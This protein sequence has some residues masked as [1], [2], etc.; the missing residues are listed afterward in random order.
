[1]LDTRPLTFLLA[2]GLAVGLA[3]S[4]P[5]RAQDTC[6]GG[7]SAV[8]DNAVFTLDAGSIA[9]MDVSGDSISKA[10]NGRGRF[11]CPNRD[12]EHFNWA[13][14]DTNGLDFCTAGSEGVY[15]Q[16]E[17]IECAR[18]S[19]IARATPNH[20][21]SGA[22]MLADFAAQAVAIKEYLSSQPAPR[23]APVLLGHNDVC[24]GSV[25]RFQAGCPRGSDQ[26]ADNHCRTTPAAFERE[27]R[28]GLD[29]L[30]TI[31][32]TRIG[33]AAMV[34][35]SQLCNLGGKRSCQSRTSCSALW[36]AAAYTG[37]I[38]GSD[39]GI[40]GSLTL[41]CSPQRVINAYRTAAG[42]RDVTERVAAEYAAVA[43]G[44]TS[45]IVNVAGQTVGGAVKAGGVVVVYSDA[46]WR[47]QFGAALLNCCDCFHP[48]PAGQNLTS[49][50]LFHGLTCSPE[51]PCCRDTGDPL[52]DARCTAVDT[53]GTF[54]PGFFN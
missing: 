44:G 18:G 35:V 43:A 22:Q 14:S 28:K 54:Y 47:V 10:F 50:V 1:M 26:D 36:K 4:T 51:T 33:L 29:I 11:P 48:S 42:Y 20:A 2:T 30:I 23:Y 19:E 53:D 27:L 41:D 7:T 8:E 52:T 46:G 5:A 37:W 21:E 25:P 6:Q 24:G 31:P 13:T 34:R 39:N 15:S 32:E 17:R 12:Q 49:A 3:S 38:F 9:S 40:C 16:A 45:P